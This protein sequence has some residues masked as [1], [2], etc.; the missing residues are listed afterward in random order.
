[1]ASVKWPLVGSK[2]DTNYRHG[3]LKSHLSWVLINCLRQTWF[4]GFIET[5][6]YF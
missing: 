1:M 3:W 6:C 4:K 2:V 5:G